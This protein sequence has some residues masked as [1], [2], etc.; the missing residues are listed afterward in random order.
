[1][2]YFDLKED[3]EYN[4]KLLNDFE[5]KDFDSKLLYLAYKGKCQKFVSSLTVQKTIRL[6]WNSSDM[7][8]NKMRKDHNIQKF[9]SNLFDLKVKSFKKLELLY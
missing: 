6:M 3:D 2:E 7:E 9:N 8:V 5:I 1:L 4:I